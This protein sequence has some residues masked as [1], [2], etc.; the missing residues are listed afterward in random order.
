MKLTQLKQLGYITGVI[1]AGL[2]LTACGNATVTPTPNINRAPQ[3]TLAPA[4]QVQPTLAAPTA[5]VISTPTPVANSSDPKIVVANALAV[6]STK[7][8]RQRIQIGIGDGKP[9][10]ATIVEFVPPDR[11]RSKTEGEDWSSLNIGAKHYILQSGKWIESKGSAPDIGA[12][13]QR[14]LVDGVNQGTF[15]I[16]PLGTETLGGAPTAV[17]QVNGTMTIVTDI[18]NTKVSMTMKDAN[19]LWIRATDGLIVKQSS[20]VE[21]GG[22]STNGTS[23]YEYDPTITIDAP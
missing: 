22:L 10:T 7:A 13:I 12:E 23:T 15:A 6:M 18:K 11:T 21:S 9:T 17:Y 16:T 14:Q 4:S 2:I 19:K 1:L 8:Y 3:P 20:Q 5:A